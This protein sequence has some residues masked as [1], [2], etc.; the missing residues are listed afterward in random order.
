MVKKTAASKKKKVER[1]K[2]AEIYALMP[3]FEDGKKEE[4]AGKKKWR[5]IQQRVTDEFLARK[6]VPK[7]IS[8]TIKGV[9]TTVTM[10]RASHMEYDGPAI[11]KVLKAAQRR[12]VFERNVDLNKLSPVARKKVLAVLSKEELAEVTTYVLN[13]DQLS[14]AVQDGKIDAKVIAPYSEEKF[15]APYI[16]VSHGTGE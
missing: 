4:A 9:V 11:W 10:T 13:A 14:Q 7:S 2:D 16:S 15:N 1:L 5:G 12:D 8:A 3:E 6:P